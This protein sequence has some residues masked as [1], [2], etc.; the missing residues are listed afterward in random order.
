M[1]KK[2]KKE[3]QYQNMQDVAIAVHRDKYIVVTTILERKKFSN[4]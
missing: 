4:Q 2:R 1:K 3:K